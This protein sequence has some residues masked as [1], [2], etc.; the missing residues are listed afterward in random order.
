MLLE[1]ITTNL[2]D[3]IEAEQYGADRIEL[4]PA[5]AEIGLT[6]SFGLL[7]NAVEA[8]NIPMNVM[9][10]PHSQ[11]FV[12]NKHDLDTMKADIELIK[13]VGANGIVIGA[14]TVKQ[15]IDEEVLKQLLDVADGLEVTFHRA[16]DFARDQVEALQCLAKYEQITTILTAG[17]NYKAPD[18]IPQLQQIIDLANDTHLSVMVGHGLRPETFADVYHQ[19]KPQAFHFGSGVRINNSFAHS[20]D[21]SKIQQVKRTMK[22][23]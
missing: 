7:K 19:L 1:V 8:V 17:G 20:L 2:T 18:A 22:G 14:L 6:P 16:F 13:K 11:S 3:V 9:V 10:R 21:R 4:S 15:T 23:N 12:Y 5:M